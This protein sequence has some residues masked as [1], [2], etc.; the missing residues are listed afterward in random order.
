MGVATDYTINGSLGI[1]T[2]IN[3]KKNSYIASHF[4]GDGH[5]ED[6]TKNTHFVEVP[7]LLAIT[8]IPSP[9]CWRTVWNAGMYVDVPI[10]GHENK[11]TF[12]GLMAG[13]QIE[14]LSHYFIRGEYQWALSSDK[15]GDKNRRSNMLSVCLGYRF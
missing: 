2:G 5:D 12:Y 8:T 15:K 9:Q 14:V 11:Q 10:G 13:L 1:Q 6:F 7:L 3:Y 4:G